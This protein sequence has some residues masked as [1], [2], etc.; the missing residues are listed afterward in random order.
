MCDNCFG[1][2]NVVQPGQIILLIRLNTDKSNRHVTY[3]LIFNFD[4]IVLKEHTSPHVHV[5]LQVPA[6]MQLT[7]PSA[8]CTCLGQGMYSIGIF[9]PTLFRHGRW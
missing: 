3:L 7:W 2:L 9:T 4:L 8:V 6:S 5:Q 1:G